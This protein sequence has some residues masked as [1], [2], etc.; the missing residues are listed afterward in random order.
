MR[1]S[2][3]G[4]N[5]SSPTMPWWRHAALP[6]A[7]TASAALPYFFAGT[8][9]IL[10]SVLLVGVM[11]GLAARQLALA[12]SDPGLTL[13][14][15][16]AREANARLVMLLQKV[17]PVWLR[18]VST[19]KDQTEQAVRE[20]IDSF[21]SMV[22]Q[23]EQAGFGGVTRSTQ[24]Q[25]QDVTI[26]LLTLC[27]RELGPVVASL[28]KIISSKDELLASVRDLAGATQELREMAADVS[29]IAAQTNLLA[30]NAAIEAAR[31]GEAGRGF[32]VVAG[33][34]R[35]LSHQSAETGKRISDRVAQISDIMT[36][37]LEAASRAAD[38]DK[39][40]ITISGSVVEDVLGHVHDL[41]S[42]AEAMRSQ[43][44]VIRADV[45]NLLVSLQYQDR[46]SQ[47]LEVIGDDMRRFGRSVASSDLPSPEQ[48]LKQLGSHY[49]M[50]EERQNH[51]SQLPAV[52]K[53]AR[54]S[55]PVLDEVTFF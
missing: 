41:G 13:A 5:A 31:A 54:A 46:I 39:K 28:E 49:T 17:L 8:T 37:T 51:S 50:E 55:A 16:E 15:Q 3:V 44:N 43:G 7:A 4:S 52:D 36:A 40:A 45:E 20:L 6:V 19:V 30:L 27:E 35:K 18:H 25:H 9:A 10:L 2:D 14:E 12:R 26:S 48:W 11:S 1:I 22:E 42:S 53:Q 47:I 29:A 33:E 34:V 38:Q 32:A 23:F 24:A 21:A